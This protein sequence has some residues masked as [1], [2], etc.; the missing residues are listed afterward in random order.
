MATVLQQDPSKTTTLR[1]SFAADVARR[2]RAIRIAVRDFVLDKDA[3]GLKPRP[4]VIINTEPR[5]FEFRTDPEKI[6]AFRQWLKRMTDARVLE[7]DA[8]GDPWVAKYVRMGYAQGRRRGYKDVL[9]KFPIPPE[10]TPV[11]VAGLAGPAT[12]E[13]IQR[14]YTR[15][16]NDLRGVT[17]AM[18]QKL[19]RIL[20]DGFVEGA[21]PLRLASEMARTIDGL[22]RSRA[23]LIARTEIIA[24]HAEA[25]L[26]AYKELRVPR[27][28]ILAEWLTAGDDRVCQLCSRMIKR[29]ITIEE[30]RGLIPLHPACRCCWAPVQRDAKVA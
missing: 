17:D 13:S 28:E 21:N 15:A 14:I 19:S 8:F 20:A 26:D 24:A 3:F 6:E 2:F 30:A 5:E 1:H 7:V 9:G 4:K 12:V 23:V 16:W 29:I 10:L 27:V 25:Q 22:S 11:I 18:G